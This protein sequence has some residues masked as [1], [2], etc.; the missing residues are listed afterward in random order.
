[1]SITAILLFGSL[2]RADQSEGSDTDLLMITTDT[3][4]HHVSVGKVSMFLYPWLQLKQEAQQ[5]NLFVCHIIREAKAIFDPDGYLSRLK[6]AFQLRTNYGNEISQATDLG[7]FLVRFGSE[8]N[9]ALEAKRTLWC[10][11]TILI[12]RSAETGHPVFSPK[13]LADQSA[14]KFAKELLARRHARQSDEAMRHCLRLFLEE[15]ETPEPLHTDGDYAAFVQRFASSMN[16]VA[17]Q[18]LR[19]EALSQ[20]GYA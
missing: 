14:S 17:L 5:G 16:K 10:I 12:A 8:L 19:Q 4:T 11:R 3:Q 20:S 15:Q 2:A 6:E 18:T 1:M 13:I 7:W 9:S